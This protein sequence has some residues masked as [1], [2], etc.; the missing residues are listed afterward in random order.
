METVPTFAAVRSLAV[1][2]VSLVPTMGYLHEGHLA[3]IAAA[4]DSTDTVVVSLFVNPL[5]FDR[6]E[7]LERYP[8]NADR[9]AALA[10]GAGAHLLFAPPLDEIYPVSPAA[11]V[12]VGALSE[13]LE[14]PKRPGHFDGVA[15]VVAKL[16]AGLQPHV[17][18]FGRK[19]AQQLAVVTRMAADLSF[20]VE[21]VG[22]PTV[23]EHD[24]LALSSRNVHLG[25][26]ERVSAGAISAG[27]MAGAAAIE[28]GERTGAALE[29]IVT[30]T[31]RSDSGLVLEY[32]ALADG[33]TARRIEHIDREAF[34]AVAAKAGSTRLIDNIRVWPD[35]TIDRG[36]SLDGPSILYEG[37]A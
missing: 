33:A 12:I 25:P 24:G 3:L 35:G 36:T 8:R 15:T 34:L 26:A 5:Q 16:F 11:R 27:L 13:Q 22:V 28:R 9:D 23:R 30:D 7:D 17:A 18:F 14:G 20:P 4:R 2:R 37:G 19:D 29:A 21:V 6:A 32:V 31:V 1:G 10:S